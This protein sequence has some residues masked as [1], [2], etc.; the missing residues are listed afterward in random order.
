M[1]VL[2]DNKVSGCFCVIKA[3]HDSVA[4]NDYISMASE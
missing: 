3:V 4:D 2:A 1:P